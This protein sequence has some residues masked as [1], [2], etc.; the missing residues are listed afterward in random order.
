[1]VEEE[2]AIANRLKAMTAQVANER[3]TVAQQL[4]A[5]KKQ[6]ASDRQKLMDQ[7][8][9]E[10]RHLEAL[11]AIRLAELTLR[12]AD[13]VDASRFA[14]AKYAAATAMLQDAHKQFDAGRWDDAVASSPWRK[15][16]RNR[17]EH[18]IKIDG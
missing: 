11:E 12:G 5:T 2:I 9:V 4:E 16:R 1:M 13:T 3:K 8:A 15:S 14:K 6:A 17:P 10:K 7:L 18:L